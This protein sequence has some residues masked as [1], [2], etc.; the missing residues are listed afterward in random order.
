MVP[1]GAFCTIHWIHFLKHLALVTECL[2]ATTPGVP[3]SPSVPVG[4]DQASFFTGMSLEMQTTL[5][6][7]LDTP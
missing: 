4:K 6:R 7:W 1:T 2:T 3:F 5:A